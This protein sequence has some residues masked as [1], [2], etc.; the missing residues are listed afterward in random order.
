MPVARTEAQARSSP[1][2]SSRSSMSETERSTVV[3]TEYPAYWPTNHSSLAEAL[4][5][6][7]PLRHI[8]RAYLLFWG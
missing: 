6:D 3:T 1:V 4:L 8:Y 2:S 5:Q 7:W